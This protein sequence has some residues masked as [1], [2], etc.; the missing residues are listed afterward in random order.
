MSNPCDVCISYAICKSAYIQN[1]IRKCLDLRCSLL[2]DWVYDPIVDKEEARKRA[3][4]VCSTFKVNCV[5]LGSGR[6]S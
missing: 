1:H 5:R 4:S 6:K 2:F 3:T